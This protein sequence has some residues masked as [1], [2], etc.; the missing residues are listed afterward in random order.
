MY[1]HILKEEFQR[2][3]TST[4]KTHRSSLLILRFLLKFTASDLTS[5]W[6]SVCWILFEENWYYPWYLSL[7]CRYFCLACTVKS[8][9]VMLMTF[10]QEPSC[11]FLD[12]VNVRQ[13]NRSFQST[14]SVIASCP[15]VKV[16]K[17]IIFIQVVLP[18]S[19]GRKARPVFIICVVSC[20]SRENTGI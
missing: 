12:N 10:H 19:L 2:R 15:S 20:S 5:D 3:S 17:C 1:A 11:P 4:E 14:A 16:C 13:Y 7:L 18:S 6:L 9:A 8:Q